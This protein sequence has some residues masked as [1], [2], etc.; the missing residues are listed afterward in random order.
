MAEYKQVFDLPISYDSLWAYCC[1]TAENIG[2]EVEKKVNGDIVLKSRDTLQTKA[3]ILVVSTS[4]E[5]TLLTIIVSTPESASSTVDVN[6]IGENI[7][8]TIIKKWVDKDVENIRIRVGIKQGLICPTCHED[9]I[10][11]IRFCPN[12]GTPISK[13][14]ENCDATNMPSAQFC[15]KC[16]KSF[17]VENLNTPNAA[18]TNLP[19]YG[20][21]KNSEKPFKVE[22]L[23]APNTGVTNLPIYGE[24]KNKSLGNASNKNS[25]VLIGVLVLI[26]IALILCFFLTWLWSYAGNS[27]FSNSATA[28][29]MNNSILATQFTHATNEANIVL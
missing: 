2:W 7:H 22:N 1:E 15:Y 9:M 11:G 24:T 8:E 13:G 5:Q 18:I 23:N 28:E 4:Q 29:A 20:E 14:C 16:G 25:A 19:I 26:G 21:T 27:K 6:Q 3:Q 12:D 10:P 17:K